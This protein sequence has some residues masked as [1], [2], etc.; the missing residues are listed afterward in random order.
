MVA[1]GS[2]GLDRETAAKRSCKVTLHLDGPLRVIPRHAVDCVGHSAGSRTSRSNVGEMGG[3]R[4]EVGATAPARGGIRPA[5]SHGARGAAGRLQRKRHAAL[6]A[7][8]RCLQRSQAA[9]CIARVAD[10]QYHF[11]RWPAATLPPPPAPPARVPA[12]SSSSRRFDSS[13]S[14]EERRRFTG[15]SLHVEVRT[16]HAREDR[17]PRI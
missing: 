11:A 5:Q 4:G 1:A 2:R 16:G 10:R 8:D 14:R 9:R 3:R 7:G 15:D 13:S 12:G 17:E 6:I